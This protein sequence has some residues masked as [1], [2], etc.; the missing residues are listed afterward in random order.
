MF[1]PDRLLALNNS[2]GL[3]VVAALN[4]RQPDFE[5][6]IDE[7]RLCLNQYDAWAE[8][9]W[10]GTALDIEQ[11]FKVGNDVQL[12][13]PIASRTP[14]SSSVV[15]CPAD[16]PLTLVHLFEAA[17][18]VPIGDTPVI[19]EPVLSDV[20]GVL[21]FGEPL[22][23]TIGSS[24]I[25]QVTDCQRGQRYRI[26]FFPDVS[27]AH[28]RA[29]YA[30]YEGVIGGLETWLRG[31]W[32]GFQPQWTE[33]SSAGFLDRYGQLQQAD[34][35]GFEKALTGLWEEIQ[36]LF[37]LLADLQ[38]HSEKLLEYLSAAELEALLAASGEAIADALLML[39]DEPLLFIHLAAFTSW[40]KMLPPQYLAEVVAEV[41]AELLISFLLVRVAG[42]AGVPLRLSSKVLA[43]IK[44]PRARDWLAASALRLAELTSTPE[45]KQHASTLKP[46]M[47]NAREVE[48]KPT[49]SI[50]LNIRQAD[51][52]V[53]NVPNPAP[54]AREKSHG[55]ARLER[56]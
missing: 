54:L 17:R 52:V 14:V 36:Q 32:T 43:K 45:L 12:S 15:M 49:P 48:L 55:M 31:E 30:S 7:F 2:I 20:G 9:F 37:A 50:A 41:R 28:V 27:C 29:L 8:Q 47:L 1:Q 5:A 19:L 21:T 39:S 33:F 26:T 24:G 10:T 53:L 16:G 25:L 56:H 23:H 6:L 42:G 34:W 22:R 11:V 3:L 35:R 38:E 46:L 18:F 13:A 51:A 44:S 4:P 40:L